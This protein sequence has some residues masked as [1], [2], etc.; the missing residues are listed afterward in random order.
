MKTSPSHRMVIVPF[1]LLSRFFLCGSAFADACPAPSFAAAHTFDAGSSP[2]W[3]AVGDFNGDG[4]SDLAVEG[5]PVAVLLGN[6][7][8]T[9]QPA[10]NSGPGGG[11]VVADINGDGKLD[12]VTGGSVLL[13]NG[14]GTFKPAVNFST[15]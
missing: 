9:F 10:V 11:P 3:V 7:D 15:G 5:S 13:G 4:K 12:L 1:I 14:D 8:G 6:G 2:F